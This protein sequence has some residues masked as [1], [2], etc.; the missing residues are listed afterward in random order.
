MTPHELRAAE[1]RSR[2]A[3]SVFGIVYLI[4]FASL[5]TLAYHAGAAFVARVVGV[6]R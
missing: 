2:L 3:W 6:L 1:L 5:A 4:S